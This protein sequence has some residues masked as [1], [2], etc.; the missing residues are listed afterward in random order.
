M[1]ELVV[2]L[3]LIINNHIEFTDKIQR[4]IDIEWIIIRN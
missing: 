3:D 2:A 1:S 4:E